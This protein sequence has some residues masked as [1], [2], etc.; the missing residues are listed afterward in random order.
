MCSRVLQGGTWVTDF[1]FGFAVVHCRFYSILESLYHMDVRRIVH[2]PELYAA[3][4]WRVNI[5]PEDRYNMHHR[6]I[7]NSVFRLW[8]CAHNVPPKRRHL[9]ARGEEELVCMIY[10]KSYHI[11]NHRSLP[12]CTWCKN[13]R[14]EFTSLV[15]H[16][17]NCIW[18]FD[19]NI[20]VVWITLWT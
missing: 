4:I 11:R 3:S 9:C 5:D 19:C 15:A 10:C 6:N 17:Q 16:D 1:F 12:I 18:C 7:D 20:Y 13:L 14:A 2:V 8:R